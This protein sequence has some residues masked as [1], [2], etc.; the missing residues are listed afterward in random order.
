MS[1]ADNLKTV[2]TQ[3][4]SDKMLGLIWIQTLWWYFWKNFSKYLILKKISRRQKIMAGQNLFIKSVQQH[5]ESMQTQE[6]TTGRHDDWP[7]LFLHCQSAQKHKTT[8]Q[9]TGLCLFGL[10]LNIPVNSYGHVRTVS[11]PYHTFFLGELDKADNQYFVHMLTLVTTLL[12][13][14]AVEIISWS[15]SPKVWDR[16]GIKLV[17][18][19]SAVRHVSVARHVTNRAIWP[20][21]IIQVSHF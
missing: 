16:A 6:Q 12:E 3:T 11:P 15:I 19:G 13:L 2:W 8:D 18:P 21:K 17:I 1:S 4:R 7:T 14:A 5:K 20:G 9:Q 10:M